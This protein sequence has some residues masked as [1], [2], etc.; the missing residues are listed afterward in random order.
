MALLYI[1]VVGCACFGWLGI[2]PVCSWQGAAAG[3]ISARRNHYCVADIFASTFSPA[4]SQ[5]LPQRNLSQETNAKRMVALHGVQQP[6]STTPKRATHPA[7]SYRKIIV[8][9][10]FSS[11]L[12]FLFSFLAELPPF[13]FRRP[14]LAELPPFVGKQRGLPLCNVW[15]DAPAGA[16]CSVLAA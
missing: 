2:Q 9:S 6:G 4:T 10:S 5:M 7:P 16:V 13:V 8:V 12:F 1:F 14:F 11:F 3:S 15:A